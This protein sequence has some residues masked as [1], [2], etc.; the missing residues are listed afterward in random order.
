VAAAL[1]GVPGFRLLTAPELDGPI[2]VATWPQISRHDMR[3]WQPQT[4]GEGLFN[5]WD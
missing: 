2:D 3:Y 5:Y 4:L 1:D